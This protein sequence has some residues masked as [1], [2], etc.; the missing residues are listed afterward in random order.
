MATVFPQQQLDMPYEATRELL[1]QLQFGREAPAQFNKEFPRQFLDVSNCCL[2]FQM[3]VQNLPAFSRVEKQIKLQLTVSPPPRQTLVHL[4]ADTIAKQKLCL[5]SAVTPNVREK[6]L[7]L[8]TYVLTSSDEPCNTCMRCMR[9]EQKRASRRKSGVSDNMN[10]ITSSHILKA[11][12]NG[13]TFAREPFN[14]LPLLPLHKYLLI[15]HRLFFK[16][17]LCNLDV[18]FKAAY[19]S[20]EL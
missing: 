10:W 8:D 12:L 18:H 1:S 3:T 9:R 13:G 11:K 20:H 4:P 15:F 5:S 6:T 17:H 2:P 16:H 14:P 7:F 19:E